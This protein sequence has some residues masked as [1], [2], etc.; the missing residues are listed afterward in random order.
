MPREDRKNKK[1]ATQ[2]SSK[3]KLENAMVWEFRVKRRPEHGK[4]EKLGKRMDRT[5]SGTDV[6]EIMVI[7]K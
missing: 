4:E 5:W 6:F 3:G 2:R 1:N 7:T